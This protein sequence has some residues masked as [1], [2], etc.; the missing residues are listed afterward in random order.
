MI[1]CIALPSTPFADSHTHREGNLEYYLKSFDYGKKADQTWVAP[2]TEYLN[3]FSTVFDAFLASDYKRAHRLGQSIGYEIIEFVDTSR[4]P[5][6]THYILQESVGPDSQN[7]K[8][9]GIFV[10]KFSAN[11]IAIQAPHPESDLYTEMQAIEIYLDS[12]AGFLFVAGSRRNSS[13]LSSPCDGKHVASDAVHN[14]HHSYYIAHQRLIEANPQTLVIQ[15]HGFGASSLKTLQTQCQTPNDKLI[16]LSEGIK[17]YSESNNEYF[18]DILAAKINQ[19]GMA[20]ACVFGQDT[21]TLGGTTNTTGRFSNGSLNPCTTNALE[22][23][24]RFIHIE[25]SFPIRSSH[26][27]DINDQIRNA[28]ETY[29]KN[30]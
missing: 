22:S 11:T 20:E 4:L 27:A 16:N 18:I 12:P 29:F 21:H 19:T 15:L 23:E 25:Q 8:G 13:T 6:E 26:R 5:I 7:Y 2:S 1:T 9:A 28:I 3:S 17:H 24:H 14:T 30:M 10:T